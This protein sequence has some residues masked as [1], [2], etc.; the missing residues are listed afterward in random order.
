MIN[1]IIF[2]TFCLI[3]FS[4]AEIQEIRIGNIDKIY[5]KKIS[6]PELR[7]ILN[8]IEILFESQLGFDVF[9]YSNTGKPIDILYIKPQLIEKR[10]VSK[11]KRLNR[12]K[13]QI[14][15]IQKS[16]PSEQLRIEE[17]QKNLQKFASHIIERTD[18]VNAYVK[19]INKQRNY[20]STQ[21]KNAQLI[22]K[23]KQER[24]KREI[25]NLRKERRVLRRMNDKYNRK[26]SKM[27]RLINSYNRLIN[28]I[29]R[30]NRS[31]QKVKGKT[32]GLKEIRLKTYF[33]NG[34]KVK[35][36]TVK[37]S[38]TKI[39]IYGFEGISKLKAVLAH[40]IAHLVGIPHIN[41]KN[42]L[43]NPILQKNQIQKLS[44][45]KEDIRNFKRN[46]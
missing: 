31:I 39:E 5:S 8:E 32:F 4:H 17:Y 14:E 7:N 1:K 19:N 18:A 35:K 16:L 15:E 2:L 9:N 12:Q 30:M 13:I 43:M 27:N 11:T 29:S 24:V 34:K 6:K 10:I 40:E 26:V 45:T 38:M 36:R 25:K 46:F 22:V 37:N 44:L 3:S 33:E 23:E 28:D 42:A 41:V 21:Y 20:T